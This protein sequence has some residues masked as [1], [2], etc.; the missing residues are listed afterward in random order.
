MLFDKKHRAIRKHCIFFAFYLLPIFHVTA[1]DIN[2]NFR[3]FETKNTQLGSIIVNSVIQDSKGFF[4]LGTE[5]GLFRFDGINFFPYNYDPLDS[6]GISDD[7][8]HGLVDVKDAKILI[9][10][11]GG[12]CLYNSEYDRFD[13][14]EFENYEIIKDKANLARNFLPALIQ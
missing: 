12:W 6:T 2:L 5:S 10:T 8:I 4:W 7:Y 14:V 11:N 13:P 3:F 9:S 1:Q